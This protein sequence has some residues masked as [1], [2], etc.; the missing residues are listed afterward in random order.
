MTTPPVLV[1]THWQ[2]Y[3]A[4]LVVIALGR[5]GV[6]V[7]RIDTDD[8]PG[9]TFTARLGPCG[10]WGGRLATDLRTVDLG[11]VRSV[12][13]GRPS[14]YLVS[15]MSPG[16]HDWSA[17]QVRMGL[18]ATLETLPCRWLN[19]PAKNR[20]A[21]H[22]PL[23]LA[24]ARDLGLNVPATLITNRAEA[25]REFVSA[26]GQ[27]VTKTLYRPM[28]LDGDTLSAIYTRLVPEAELADMPGIELVP[29]MFQAW[30]DKTHDVRVIAVGDCLFAAEIHADSEAGRIDWRADHKHVTYRPCEIPGDVSERIRAF[31]DRLGLTYGAFDFSIDRDATWWFLEC[32]PNGQWSW[33]VDAAGLPIDEAIATALITGESS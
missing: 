30:I 26:V 32:N 12:Y 6:P 27:V 14:A 23:Q 13:L 10:S 31:R 7:F 5:H 11:Q 4:D 20:R 17:G 22:K 19:H 9:L 3:A 21:E 15:E 28:L 33:L 18:D 8:L 1:W 24:T 16:V 25:V 2:D 29:H